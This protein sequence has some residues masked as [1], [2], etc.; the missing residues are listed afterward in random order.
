VA[1][2]V[3]GVCEAVMIVLLADDLSGH[4]WIPPLVCALLVAA[5]VGIL[6]AA[7]RRAPDAPASG[8]ALVVL[9]SG[10]AFAAFASTALLLAIYS[11]S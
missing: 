7:R 4:S 1:L 9:G 8:R 2:L 6:R 3:L 10:V 11:I 5:A